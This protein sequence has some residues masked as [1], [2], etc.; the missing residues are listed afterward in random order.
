MKTMQNVP[1]YKRLQLKINKTYKEYQHLFGFAEC[2]N[3]RKKML[4]RDTKTRV[5]LF[6]RLQ[7][8]SKSGSG[9]AIFCY[10]IGNKGVLN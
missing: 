3:V 6:S 7:T 1:T 4:I 5:L 9:F 10:Y 8:T 2:C